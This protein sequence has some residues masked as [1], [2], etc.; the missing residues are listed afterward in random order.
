MLKNLNVN[1]KRKILKMLNFKM[2]LPF[3]VTQY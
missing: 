3:S 2:F 1:A